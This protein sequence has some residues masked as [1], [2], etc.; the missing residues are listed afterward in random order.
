MLRN[1][2]PETE[3]GFSSKTRVF[4]LIFDFNGSGWLNFDTL[5]FLVELL[6]DYHNRA[7]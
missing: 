1:A 5:S 2:L 4:P 7:L 3:L 6:F